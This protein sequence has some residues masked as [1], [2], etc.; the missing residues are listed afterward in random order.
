MIDRSEIDRQL[1]VT[2]IEK[3]DELKVRELFITI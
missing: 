1:K 2:A 3:L